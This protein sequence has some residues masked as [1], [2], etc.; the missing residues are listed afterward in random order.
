LRQPQGAG[1]ANAAASTCHQYHLVFES[2]HLWPLLFY[3][4][5][6]A[7]GG[8]SGQPVKYA[9]INQFRMGATCCRILSGRLTY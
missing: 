7:P 9:S 6:H 5:Q 2:L 1:L 3:R 8:D 4:S